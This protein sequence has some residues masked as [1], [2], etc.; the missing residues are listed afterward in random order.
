MMEWRLIC[1]GPMAGPVNMATDR[2]LLQACNEGISGPT[3]RIYGWAGT[4]VTLG[5]A[6]EEKGQINSELCQRLNIPI[7]RRPT[8]GRAMAHQNELTYSLTVPI[9][10]EQFPSSLKGAYAVVATAVEKSLQLLGVK[11]T[12]HAPRSTKKTEGKEKFRSPACFAHLNGHEVAVQGKKLTGGAQRRLKGAFL[13]QGSILLDCDREFTNSLFEFPDL[14]TR[15][16]NLEILREQTISLRELLGIEIPFEL[17]A[18]V[19]KK[20]FSET[21]PGRWQE[22][23][24]SAREISLRDALVEDKGPGISR[25]VLDDAIK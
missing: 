17:A 2:A 11:N 16:R 25:R 10:H 13:Q 19:F 9:P 18:G 21:F 24:L 1:D 5:Y 15:E 23:G 20:G 8:G 6:Q 14:Q 12:P 22:K 4:A 3:F 7:S